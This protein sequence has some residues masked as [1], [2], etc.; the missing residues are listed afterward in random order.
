MNWL[1]RLLPRSKTSAVIDLALKKREL[2]R[3]A[4]EAGCSRAMAIKVASLYFKKDL[5]SRQ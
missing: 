3:V 5:E 2:Q 1:S 4:Q